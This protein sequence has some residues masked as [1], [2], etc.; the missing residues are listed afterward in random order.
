MK[1]MEGQRTELLRALKII[2]ARYMI[3]RAVRAARDVE[4]AL[5]LMREEKLARERERNAIS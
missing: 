1:T 2:K 5:I 4:Y 3:D